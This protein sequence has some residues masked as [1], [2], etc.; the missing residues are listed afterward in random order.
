MLRYIH[1]LGLISQIVGLVVNRDIFLRPNPF[2]L[3][4]RTTA[5]H[6][7]Q[8]VTQRNHVMNQPENNDTAEEQRNAVL[9]IDIPNHGC[10]G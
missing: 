3:P 8:G 5:D 6:E 10:N 2:C 1:R 4:I 9:A 7:E